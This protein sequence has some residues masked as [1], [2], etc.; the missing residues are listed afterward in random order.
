MSGTTTNGHVDLDAFDN[1][2][3]SLKDFA[4]DI[5]AGTEAMGNAVDTC[6]RAMGSDEY[7]MQIVKNLSDCFDEYK[8]L[9]K[10]IGD[11]ITYLEKE[12]EMITKIKY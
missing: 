1:M 2:I 4:D 5:L 3:Q 6:Q 8:N 10:A 11:E 7:S 12:K 9:I